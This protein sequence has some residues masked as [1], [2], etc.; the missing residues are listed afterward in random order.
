M[1]YLL[2]QRFRNAKKELTA[3]KTAH[4]RG[5]GNVRIFSH[6]IDLNTSG[7]ETGIWYLN[8]T[9]N[10]SQS[11]AAYPFV[12]FVPAMNS[13]G[14]SSIFETI[15]IDYSNGGFSLSSRMLYIYES[16]LNSFWI[17]STTPI[18]SASYNW[19]SP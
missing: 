10:F 14:D 11:F 2:S 15:G 17:Y 1:A 9:V 18:T 3:L 16:G 7:H 19:E 13:D 5:F 6:R 4:K 12:T 8:V